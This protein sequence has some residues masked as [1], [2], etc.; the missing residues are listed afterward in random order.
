MTRTDMGTAALAALLAAG[1]GWLI[2]PEGWMGGDRIAIKPARLVLRPGE[3][4]SVE[5]VNRERDVIAL[6]FR[7][8]FDESVVAIEDAEPTHVSILDGGQAINLAARWEAG[9]VVVPALAVAGGRAFALGRP[10]FRFRVRGR[11]AGSATVAVEDL[12]IVDRGDRVEPLEVV[13]LEVAVR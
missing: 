9:V 3:A 1:I 6:S 4:A 10:F 5:L 7:L 13:P 12:R 11:R 8:R 2:R